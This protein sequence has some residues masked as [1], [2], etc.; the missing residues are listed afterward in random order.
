MSANNVF[1]LKCQPS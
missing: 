1:S